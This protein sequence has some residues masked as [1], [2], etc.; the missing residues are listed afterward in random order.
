MSLGDLVGISNHFG[1]DPEFVLAGGGNTSFKDENHLYIK[2][3]GT[4]LA[5]ITES[6]FVRM[7]RQKLQI[8]W[9][10]SYPENS[11]LRESQVLEDLMDARDK[12][13]HNKRPSVETSLHDSFPQSFVVHTHPAL[14]NALT[15]SRNGESEVK[16]LFGDKA[17]W[18][19]SMNPGYILAKSV[20]SAIDEYILRTGSNPELVFLQNHGIFIAADTT[21]EI[22]RIT[23][24]VIS[25]IQNN[26]KRMPDLIGSEPDKDKI[27][28]IAPAVRMLLKENNPSSVLTFLTNNEIQNLVKD[29]K[30]FSKAASAFTPDHIVYCR[31]EPLFVETQS[32]TESTLESLQYGIAQYKARNGF[33]P[34]VIA[35]E[36]LGVFAWG[37]NKKAAD[38]AAALFLDTV[39]I[40][41]Y[42]ESFG[43][44]QFMTKDQIDFILNW[45]VESYRAKIS[46]A[47]GSAKRLSDKIAIV[48][49]SA[50][51]FGR[52][53]AEEMLKQGAYVVI[54]D[55]NYDLA[56]E[57]A[58]IFC[59]EFGSGKAYPIQTDVTNEQS[60]KNM[61]T[62]TVLMYGGLDILVSN[63]GV[64]KAGSLD[65]MEL[66]TFE[67]VTNVNYTA[68][69]ICAKYASKIMKAQHRF[70]PEYLMDII[71]I[72]SKSGLEGSNKNFAYAG[73]KFGGIGLVQSFALE[74]LEYKIKVNAV[75]PGNF[76][77]GPLWSNPE[78]G[79]F[80]QYLRSGKVPGAVS[81]EDVKRYYE[82]RVPMKR[83]CTVIDV[84]RAILYIIEQEYETGQAVP[85]T[86]G[87]VM[88]R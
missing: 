68:F 29:K 57:A 31:H 19:N 55:I 8:I 12:G 9:Q 39:K 23:G 24:D 25:T 30:S 59:N 18:I 66:K 20:K 21:D 51:G 75:C 28:S 42:A 44:G 38:T 62:E 74:L 13:E 84:A 35:I 82:H 76:F 34:K 72:N 48:T 15:C 81:I 10:K 5:D 54:A 61:I 49:G 37:M 71:E 65:E 22:K 69:F 11:D 36:K 32:D 86:G 17:I 40:S 78:N 67:F 60:V 45:E 77:E 58:S 3:S 27:C 41:C 43:G 46:L 70:D 63:A 26:I 85:V 73:S 50:Q 2:G 6:G 80:V 53:I 87:Q 1:A 88:L 7:N 4:T 47:A 64:L 33:V 79:L 52:G 56:R 83:G 14:I 16:K